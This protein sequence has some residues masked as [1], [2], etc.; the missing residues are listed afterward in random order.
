MIIAFF[1]KKYFLDK[2]CEK[3]TIK[4][5]SNFDNLCSLDN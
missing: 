3:Y 4:I 2:E 5:V 1:V